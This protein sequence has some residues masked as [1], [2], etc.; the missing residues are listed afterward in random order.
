M[1]GGLF[2]GFP[3]EFN[4]KCIIFTA[5]LAGGYWYLPPK[6]LWVLVFLLWAP[7]VSLAWYDYSYDCRIKMKYSPI[8]FGRW[9]FLPF[10]PQGYKDQF[11][12][13]DENHMWWVRRIDHLTAWTLVIAGA[14]YFILRKK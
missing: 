6:N 12:S 7:Y 8:P 14:G 1:A 4:I 5:L 10:K 9:I 3:F 2:P 13:L 11:N